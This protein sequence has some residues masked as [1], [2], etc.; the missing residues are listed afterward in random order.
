MKDSVS[1]I[2]NKQNKQKEAPLSRTPSSEFTANNTKQKTFPLKM[3]SRVVFLLLL[4][5]SVTTTYGFHAANRVKTGK[6]SV[7]L[8]EKKNYSISTKKTLKEGYRPPSQQGNGVVGFIS[9]AINAV[10]KSVAGAYESV[11]HPSADTPMAMAEPIQSK[12]PEA[13]ISAPVVVPSPAV[14]ETPAAPAG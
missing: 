12:Q 3:L 6:T 5:L 11:T 8:H 1:R 14:S 10:K 4:L 9:G 13:T 7:V 2:Y